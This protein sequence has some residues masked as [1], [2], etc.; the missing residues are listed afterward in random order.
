MKKTLHQLFFVLLTCLLAASLLQ[1]QGPDAFGYTWKDSNDPEGPVFEWI[2]ISSVGTEVTGLGDDNSVAMMP[3]GMDFRF[4]W[5]DFDRI[6]IGSNGW[7]S[8]DNVSNIASCFPALPTPGG[9]NNLICPLMSDLNFD[10]N[11][12]GKMYTYLDDTPGDEKFIIS[13]ENTT[14]WTQ[15][16]PIFGSNTFQVILSS[17]DS[18][19]TFQYGTMD[20]DFAYP[21][22][23]G[24]GKVG[25]GI[26]NLTGD[27]GLEVFG[28]VVPPSNYAVKFYYPQVITF[29]ITDIAPTAN[30]N[31]E[32]EGVFLLPDEM[33]TLNATVSNTGNTDITT[34]IPVAAT[35]QQLDGSTIFLDVQETPPLAAGE[36]QTVD[37]MPVNVDWGPGTYFYDVLTALD[38]DVNPSN[39]HNITELNVVDLNAETLT[40]GYIIGMTASGAMQWSGGGD[41][42]SG[43]GIEIEPP[44]YPTVV[45]GVQVGIAGGSTDG[46]TIRLFDD[47]GPNGGPGTELS[48]IT[49]PAGAY[50]AG[51]IN[52]IELDSPVTITDGSFYIG[53]FMEGATV[54]LLVESEGPIS[55][56]TYE[57]LSNSWAK[58]RTVADAM[59]RAVVVNPF[60][61]ATKDVI[62]NSPLR[63]YPN[64]NNGAF[65]IDNT[66]GEVSIEQIRVVNALGATVFEKT[67]NVGV[68]QQLNVETGLGTGLY[69]LELRTADE[70]RIIRKVLVD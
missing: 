44:F 47:D 29:S 4:Y 18:S 46:F 5:S 70:R 63:V 49:I 38:G 68:G 66:L 65:N 9:P 58:Y 14:F 10:N 21:T 59:L 28:G 26:E 60:F 23:T 12:P 56:R 39:D 20:A 32:N 15:T 34:Q 48:A 42:T 17:A 53:W 8:F 1:A 13:Y 24:G 54:A 45:T 30:L 61:V 6:K 22:C 51:A 25:V 57:V 37:F 62:A 7:L 33:V 50:L 16:D 52:A 3:M 40:L 35:V 27:I 64:P 69:F 36:S 55:N 31:A 11:S 2:D 67:Q 19:I 43:G 41:G